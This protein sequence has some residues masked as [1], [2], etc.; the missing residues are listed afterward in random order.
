M[1]AIRASIEAV[2]DSVASLKAHAARLTI[3]NK[4]SEQ[5]DRDLRDKLEVPVNENYSKHLG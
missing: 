4:M 3:G 1:D 5:A 2:L